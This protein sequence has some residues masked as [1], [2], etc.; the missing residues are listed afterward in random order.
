MQANTCIGLH[1]KIK[2]VAWSSFKQN[3]K[4]FETVIKLPSTKSQEN[5][6]SCFRVVTHGLTNK[7]TWRISYAQSEIILQRRTKQLRAVPRPGPPQA[8]VIPLLLYDT[9]WTYFQK[10]LYTVP[11]LRFTQNKLRRRTQDYLQLKSWEIH[12]TNY[13][14]RRKSC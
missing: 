7:Q 12:R 6:V 8:E 10:H 1:V 5:S 9:S 3:K 11:S 13:V 14:T 2:F 4:I